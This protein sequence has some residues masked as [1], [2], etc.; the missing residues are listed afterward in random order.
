M[1]LPLF[2]INYYNSRSSNSYGG[3]FDFLFIV[4]NLVLAPYGNA[5]TWAVCSYH[6]RWWLACG[7]LQIFLSSSLHLSVWQWME[8]EEGAN[9]A[10]RGI[11]TGYTGVRLYG[12][13]QLWSGDGTAELRRKG[14]QLR[15]RSAICTSLSQYSS[16]FT[17]VI[18][19]CQ[20]RK[21]NPYICKQVP[22]EATL[23]LVQESMSLYE[24]LVPL[25]GH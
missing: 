14:K 25:I 6:V 11:R 10:R 7:V 3:F 2:Y 1:D 13:W 19:A 17:D 20:Y 12:H 16:F 4:V 15:G 22:E 18:H 24:T 8:E 5:F 23:Y 9:G 21:E